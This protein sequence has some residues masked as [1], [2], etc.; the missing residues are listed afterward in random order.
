MS[1]ERLNEFI[2]QLAVLNSS[3]RQTIKAFLE[4]QERK[5]AETKN[6]ASSDLDTEQPDP[7]RRREYQWVKKHREQ[8]AGQ[9]VALF[10]DTLVA[11]GVDG[12]EVLRQARAAG[13][14]R[15]LMVR[16]EAADE[17]HSEDGEDGK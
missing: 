2:K 17:P 11:H 9:Y 3:E 4:E 12:R 14:P 13:F 10:G 15:A 6:G 16:I 8:Y 7:L 5:D 1:T